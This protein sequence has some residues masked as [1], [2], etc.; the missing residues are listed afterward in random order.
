[1]EGIPMGIEWYRELIICIAGVVTCI[2]VLVAAG[3]IIYFAVIV[4][5]LNK[6]AKSIMSTVEETTVIAK[7]VISDIREDVSGVKE[8]IMSPLIQVMAIVQG[9]RKG[10]ELVNTF[11]R[12]EKGGENA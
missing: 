5:S 2:M 6:K 11:L 7:G 8:E 1:M 3:A 9:V 12:K 4:R 10:F